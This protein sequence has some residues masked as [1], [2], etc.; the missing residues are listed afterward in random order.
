MFSG[1]DEYRLINSEIVALVDQLPR[2][3][4]GEAV[5]YILSSPGKRVRPLI[6]VSSSQAFGCDPTTSVD[7]SLAVEMVHAASLVH[8]DI[9]DW[10]VERRGMP[11]A[12]ERY[13]DEVAILSGDYMISRSIDL[14]SSYSHRVIKAFSGACMEMA[15][16]ELLDLTEVSSP[17]EYYNCIYKK[18]ASLFEA[19][20]EIGCLI[21]CA[22]DEDVARF[23]RY[24][25][26]LGLAYQIL[27]DLEEYL[28]I[29]QGKESSKTSM[30]LPRIYGDIFSPENS[31]EICSKAIKDHCA[32][33]KKALKE[34]S[35]DGLALSRLQ[36]IVDYMTQRGLEECRSLKSL[37]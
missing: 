27:D 29:S 25:S 9:L 31:L 34:S 33:A 1:W 36:E 4:L 7:A 26:N 23:K 19:S 2:S 24:G 35:G 18:T 3:A 11:S 14:I 5:G 37:C 22:P 10:G 21:A 30:T 28:G 16:G 13:G 15:E 12:F 17:E 8:D 32:E 6:L 20:V